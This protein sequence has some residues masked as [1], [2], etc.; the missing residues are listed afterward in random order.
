MEARKAGFEVQA[1]LII[2]LPG[3]TWESFVSDVADTIALGATSVLASPLMAFAGTPMGDEPEVYGLC[4]FP[5]PQRFAYWME[6][7]LDA[8]RQMLSAS[9]VLQESKERIRGLAGRAAAKK[10]GF[11]FD[12]FA[13]KTLESD[14]RAKP[15]HTLPEWPNYPTLCI[16]E[17]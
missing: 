1:D 11:W 15:H 9:R 3:Q 12:L 8:Y 5:V 16:G 13:K 4:I 10:P 17:T 14:V 2:G 6:G 7:G